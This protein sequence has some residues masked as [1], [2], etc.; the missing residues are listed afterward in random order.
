VNPV[1]LEACARAAHEV[2]RAYC[3]AIGDNSQVSWDNA[4][5][6][7]K[8]SALEGVAVA[9]S[10]ST[11]EQQHQSWLDS[12]S[13]DGWK[14]G[15]VKDP[16]LK[17]HPCFVPYDQLPEAQKKKDGLYIGAVRTMAA[18]LGATITYPA[19]LGRPE[20]ETIDWS[21]PPRP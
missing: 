18:A 3:I 13:K 17:T 1:I 2:N 11:P 4:P 7:Q 14:Y 16:A 12:K 21:L 8:K 15:T 10:G 20:A 9:L 5:E 19:G 6:W